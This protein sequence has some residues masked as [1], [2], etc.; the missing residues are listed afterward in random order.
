VRPEV[1]VLIAAIGKLVLTVIVSV[2]GGLLLNRVLLYYRL[3]W[4]WAVMGLP[5]ALLALPFNGFWAVGVTGIAV[6]AAAV[7]ARWHLD[8]LDSGM[9]IAERAQD[10]L[11]IST[12]ARRSLQR[13][14]VQR[15]GW[16]SSSRL[17]VGEDSHGLPVSIPVG[18]QSG[19]HTLVLGATG[20]GKTVSETWIA[21]RLIDQ[22]H[23][24]IVIDPKGD[25]LLRDELREAAARAQRPFLEWTPEGPSAYNPYAHGGASEI[26]DKALAG[27]T[28]TEPHYLRQAQRYLGHAIRALHATKQTVSP[29]LL[30]QTMDTSRLDE[31]ARELPDDQAEPVHQYLDSLSDRQ[32]RDLTGIRDRLSILAESDI[33]HLLEPTTEHPAIDLQEAVTQ[34]SVVYFRLD[35]DRHALLSQMLAAAI[36]SDLIT[37]VATLQGRPSPTVVVIDEFAAVAAQHVVRLFGRARSAGISLVLGTQELADLTSAGDGLRE[38][39][40]GNVA[41]VVAHRQSVPESAELIAGIAST[42]AVWV[43]TQQTEEHLLGSQRA[44]RGT[45]RRGYEYELHPRHIKM[46]HT[47]QAAVIAPGSDCRPAVTRMYHPKKARS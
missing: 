19:S 36:I 45:R 8:E 33:G 13:R 9:D 1:S 17:I 43:T 4:T 39:V 47:G 2:P 18:Y 27:E 35:A 15:D 37:L 30:M 21:A 20:S 23:G 25:R 3:R 7:G 46:L 16:V 6:F 38:Q 14:R 26:A 34:R 28:F 24:A 44:R 29:R 22:G 10:R 41:A 40:L 31:L 11:T 32:K 12:V 5:I 42:K